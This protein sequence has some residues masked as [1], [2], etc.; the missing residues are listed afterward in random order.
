MESKEEE[1]NM[2]SFAAEEGKVVCNW[3]LHC[4]KMVVYPGLAEGE[5]PIDY[6]LL[7]FLV[8]GEPAARLEYFIIFKN[9]HIK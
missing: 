8:A 3:L 9:L 2:L 4:I 5:K 1:V 7:L 6:F